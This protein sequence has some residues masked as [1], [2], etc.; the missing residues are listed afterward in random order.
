MKQMKF[1]EGWDE[2]RV[3]NLLASYEAQTEEEAVA[4]NEAGVESSETVMSIPYELV[5]RVRASVPDNQN[6]K[7]ILPKCCC[8][9]IYRSAS[10]KS[11]Q[12]K[13]RSTTGLMRCNS[14]AR[15]I[16]SNIAREPT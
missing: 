6:F 15:I 2:T 11:V 1:P 16:R 9:S 13:V 7:Q 3:R 10:L 14:M 4:E 8:D 5:P 12:T